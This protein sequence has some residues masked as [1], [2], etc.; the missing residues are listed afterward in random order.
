MG[1]NRIVTELFFERPVFAEVSKV[2][3]ELENAGLKVIMLPPEDRG[4]NTHLVVETSDT[5]K[6]KE[7]CNGM[8]V[9]VTDKESILIALENRP[10]TMAAAAM[11]M[12]EKGINL[13]YAFSVT[14]GPEKSYILIGAEDNQ[15]ALK[16]LE[17]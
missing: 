16:A 9:N 5:E 13:K 11:K 7:I 10:G 8:G 4:I 14:M 6:A 17:E 15:A 12:S 3:K 1:E 2:A